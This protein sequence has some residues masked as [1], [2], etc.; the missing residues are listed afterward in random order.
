M[1][2]ILILSTREKNLLSQ[3][4]SDKNIINRIRNNDTGN[5]KSSSSGKKTNSVLNIIAVILGFP[6]F[7][8]GAITHILPWLIARKMVRNLVRDPAWIASIK[9]VN[10]LFLVPLFYLAYA[11]LVYYFT[12]CIWITLAF[13]LSL[14]LAGLAAYHYL[15]RY[16]I[17]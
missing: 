7:V 6:V 11:F 8:Y 13:F 4:H 2:A 9:F 1:K 17:R 14:H 10:V 12:G 16:I 15:Y 3:L 5:L